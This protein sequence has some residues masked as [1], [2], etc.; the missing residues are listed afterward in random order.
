VYGVNSIGS[1]VDEFDAEMRMM[2]LLPPMPSWDAAHPIVIHLPLGLAMVAPVFLAMAAL[3]P[4][5]WRRGLGLSCM[6]LVA[7]MAIGSVV[8][9]WS[10]E[11]AEEPIDGIL[12]APATE[13][14][15]RHEELGAW[16]RNAMIG[17]A[18]VYAGVLWGSAWCMRKGRGK[19]RLALHGASGL[20]LLGVMA[21]MFNAAHLGGRLV[22]EFGV[23][24]PMA[25]YQG[26]ASNDEI[27][28]GLRFHDEDED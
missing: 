7:A 18:V 2:N 3:A 10:G 14:L 17:F 28:P 20:F 9:V 6:V 21:L 15:E 24:A 23:H 19:W 13:V 4:E 25:R 12:S 27:R 5:R 8:A 11:T 1:D 22:H 16:T 26:D